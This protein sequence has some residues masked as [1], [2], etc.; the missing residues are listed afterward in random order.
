VVARRR[1]PAGDFPA[2]AGADTTAAAVTRA[3]CGR[4][5]KAIY[6]SAESAESDRRSMAEAAA[7]N[8]FPRPRHDGVWHVGHTS[9]RLGPLLAIERAARR[10]PEPDPPTP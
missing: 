3:R 4:C 1:A 10:P 9:A 8:V 7:L 5:R 2:P 6:T